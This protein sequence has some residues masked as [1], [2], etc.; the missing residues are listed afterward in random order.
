MCVG[1][2]VA[3]TP[4]PVDLVLLG[5]F[6]WAIVLALFASRLSHQAWDEMA[7][8]GSNMQQFGLEAGRG[9]GRIRL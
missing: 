4:M 6:P 9:Q 7:E 3:I 2:V 8:D 1:I 5:V